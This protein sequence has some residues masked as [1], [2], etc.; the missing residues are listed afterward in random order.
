MLRNCA[1]VAFTTAC[2]LE[3]QRIN[4]YFEGLLHA[5]V[6]S[7]EKL[8][9]FCLCKSKHISVHIF[10]VYCNDIRRRA[11]TLTFSESSQE[12]QHTAELATSVQSNHLFVTSM[13]TFII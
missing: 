13:S 11:V 3:K 1:L 10:S 4:S 6:R 2:F 9:F 8:C 7:I 5:F 12:K